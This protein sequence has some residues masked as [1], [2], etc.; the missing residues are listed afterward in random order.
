MQSL[1]GHPDYQ[2]VDILPFDDQT[3]RDSFT[4][5]PGHIENVKSLHQLVEMLITIA[6]VGSDSS[7][8]ARDQV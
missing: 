8:T 5:Q 7:W 2:H 6:V 3:L 4:L 1:I